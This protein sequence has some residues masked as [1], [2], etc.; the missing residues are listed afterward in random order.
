[1]GVERW[2]GRRIAGGGLVTVRWIPDPTGEFTWLDEGKDACIVRSPC[3]DVCSWTVSELPP[4]EDGWERVKPSG[5]FA[6]MT[7][8]T[9]TPDPEPLL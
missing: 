1:M 8:D 7:D 2:R 6:P 4:A 5:W 9:S 3:G